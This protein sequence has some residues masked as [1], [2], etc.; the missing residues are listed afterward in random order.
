[1]ALLA[2]LTV[3]IL[4]LLAGLLAA[5][6]LLAGF[7]TR[8]LVLLARILVGVGHSGSPFCVAGECN[9]ETTAKVRIRFPKNFGSRAIIAWRRFVLTVTWEPAKNYPVQSFKL[10]HAL[11]P[12]PVPTVKKPSATRRSGCRGHRSVTLKYGSAWIIS[13]SN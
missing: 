8:A 11:L 2:T 7:L 10:H 3:R 5:A 13:P 9:A 4:L 12:P 1:L 6:L